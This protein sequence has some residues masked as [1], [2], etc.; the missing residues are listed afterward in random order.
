MSRNKIQ[1][2]SKNLLEYRAIILK[3]VNNVIAIFK[4]QYE[5]ICHTKNSF[6]VDNY[7]KM[8]LKI[9]ILRK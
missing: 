3:Y 6:Y 1:W 9:S 2:E 8:Y 5:R 4:I 7:V